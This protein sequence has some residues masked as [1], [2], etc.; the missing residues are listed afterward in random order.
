MQKE[1][2]AWQAWQKRMKIEEVCAA[3]TAAGRLAWGNRT[4][5]IYDVSASREAIFLCVR[6]ERRRGLSIIILAGADGLVGGAELSSASLPS[7]A[8]LADDQSKQELYQGLR[9]FGEELG[10]LTQDGL[11]PDSG[12]FVG[13]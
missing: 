8:R 6:L 9:N 10:L 11:G 3:L 12:N 13:C 4:F 7:G 2:A 5:V 1:L